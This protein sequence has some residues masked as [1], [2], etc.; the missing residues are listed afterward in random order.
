[1]D[2]KT[3]EDYIVSQGIKPQTLKSE[4]R[5]NSGTAPSNKSNSVVVVSAT[6]EQP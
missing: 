2:H 4:V 3:V 6:V 5:A 1:M